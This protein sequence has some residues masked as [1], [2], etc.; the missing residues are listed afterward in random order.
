[1]DPFFSAW[2]HLFLK[3]VFIYFDFISSEQ[4]FNCFESL[5]GAMHHHFLLHVFYSN[6]C[7]SLVCV[8]R[9]RNDICH[10]YHEGGSRVNTGGC[11]YRVNVHHESCQIFFLK[12]DF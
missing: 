2:K 3:Y 7:E 12:G 11:T 6:Y 4:V 5:I 1:M 10:I 8:V 9:F